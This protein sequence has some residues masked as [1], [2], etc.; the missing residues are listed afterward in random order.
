MARPVEN[1]DDGFWAYGIDFPL[2]PQSLFSYT[3][4]EDLK[5]RKNPLGSSKMLPIQTH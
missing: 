2:E 4:A 3:L 1:A 5:K